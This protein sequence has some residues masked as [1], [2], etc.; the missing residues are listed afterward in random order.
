MDCLINY[1]ANYPLHPNVGFCTVFDVTANL[2][3]PDRNTPITPTCKMYELWKPASHKNDAA[4]CCLM[5]PECWAIPDLLLNTDKGVLSQATRQVD[6][7]ATSVSP[8]GFKRVEQVQDYSSEAINQQTVKK[9]LINHLNFALI[10]FRHFSSWQEVK[11]LDRLFK[12]RIV[13]HQH[14]TITYLASC[15]TDGA[16]QASTLLQPQKEKPLFL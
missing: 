13:Y 15:F 2:S 14:C 10:E 3:Q 16:F 1:A 8:S 7:A 6:K 11:P 12:H 5:H 9:V 4:L